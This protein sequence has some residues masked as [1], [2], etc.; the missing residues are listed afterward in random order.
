MFDEIKWINRY[1]DKKESLKSDKI[2]NVTNF[3]LMWNIFEDL[4][5]S[6][7]ASVESI[8]AL[9]DSLSKMNA[10]GSS[11]SYEEYLSYFRRRYLTNGG[12]NDL[13][14]KLHFRKNEGEEKRLVE[15]VLLEAGQP[16]PEDT[17]KA[18]MLVVYRF[19][20]NLFHGEKDISKIELQN[21]NFMKA[22]MLLAHILE[23]VKEHGLL[24]GEIG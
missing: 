22:N 21:E 10:L 5:C 17:V 3:V 12:T 4:T 19:R 24:K 1:F 6:R 2:R 7:K 14:D 11:D 18:L 15:S 23:K 13:F 8:R 9:I 16:T 20:N